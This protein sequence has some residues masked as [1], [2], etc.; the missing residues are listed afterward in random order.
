MPENF[1]GCE[2]FTTS[3]NSQHGTVHLLLLQLFVSYNPPFD[4]PEIKFF[5]LLSQA[6]NGH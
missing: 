2:N 6:I 4:V 3:E 5:N 1:S